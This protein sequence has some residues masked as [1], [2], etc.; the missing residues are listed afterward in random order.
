MQVTTKNENFCYKKLKV[1]FRAAFPLFVD[2]Y[3][4]RGYVCLVH[5]QG[6]IRYGF[7]FFDT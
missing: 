4:S 5:A 6:Q 3:T 2:Y 7:L 1:F